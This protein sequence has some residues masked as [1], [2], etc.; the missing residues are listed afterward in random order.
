MDLSE[1]SEENVRNS[2]I[3]II[4]KN[5]FRKGRARITFFDET[6][7]YIWTFKSKRKTGF[8]ITTADFRKI[9]K[10]F[11]LTVSPLRINSLSPLANIKSG[12][13]LEK[14][15]ALKDARVKG[16]DEAVC[17]NERGKVVSAST[18]NIFWVKNKQIFTSPLQTGC[19]AGTTREIILENFAVCE[20][21]IGI[22]ELLKADEIFLTSSGI[23][24]MKVGNL[25]NNFYSSFS[26]TENLQK[27]LNDSIR[28]QNF[29]DLK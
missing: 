28:K 2:L 9:K 14:L 1:L 3:E 6:S 19:L 8:L 15:L 29:L 25:E 4:E 5:N 27:F 22:D 10:H 24:V 11:R 13:Y 18:A 7:S 23:G 17:L 20:K 21:R 12:N 26:I 16:F